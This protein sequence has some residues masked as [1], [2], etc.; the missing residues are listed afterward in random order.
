MS[1]A[2]NARSVAPYFAIAAL[3]MVMAVL[4]LRRGGLFAETILIPAGPALTAGAEGEV[5][6]VKLIT[7]L[8]KDAIPAIFD[9]S[10]IDAEAAN[11]QLVDTDL[12]I[13]VTVNGEHRAYGVAFLSAH[14]VV[15]D[16]VGGR[17]IAVTW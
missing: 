13:G 11:R 10:F 1:L 7:L 5:R 4:V 2:S 8:P 3:V 15:N 6:S 16:V 14:E 12:V 17:A 9:P